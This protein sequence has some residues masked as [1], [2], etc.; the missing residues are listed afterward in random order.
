[1]VSERATAGSLHSRRKEATPSDRYGGPLR[2]AGD[3]GIFRGLEERMIS[4]VS[5]GPFFSLS[6]R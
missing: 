5:G 1:V 3:R 2:R 4:T 6:S